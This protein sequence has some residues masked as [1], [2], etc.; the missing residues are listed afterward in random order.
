[1][2]VEQAAKIAGDTTAGVSLIAV[3]FNYLPNAVAVLGLLWYLY[4]IWS[5]SQDNQRKNEE[6]RRS[7]EYH[8]AR[9]AALAKSNRFIS[10]YSEDS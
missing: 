8:E 1:M 9:M 6:A 4:Q 2:Q 7:E 3:L 10:E 5:K